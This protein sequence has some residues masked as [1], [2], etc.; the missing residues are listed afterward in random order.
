MLLLSQ[1]RHFYAP[2][3]CQ[4]PPTGHFYHRNPPT[5]RPRSYSTGLEVETKIRSVV[6]TVKTFYRGQCL[7]S[8][9]RRGGFYS[10]GNDDNNNNNNRTDRF[11]RLPCIPSFNIS[12]TE[13]EFSKF[14]SSSLF[15]RLIPS[16]LRGWP[17]SQTVTIKCSS[18]RTRRQPFN[19]PICRL[20]ISILCSHLPV[21]RAFS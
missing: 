21:R 14:S 17:L 11:S 1:A 16:H 2:A 4:P 12:T 6:Y 13:N 19:V 18:T 20:S 7:R 9:L 15:D 3:V 10:G 8:E 5:T